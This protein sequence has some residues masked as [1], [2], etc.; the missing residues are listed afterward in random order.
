M[1]N[2]QQPELR[3][4]ERGSTTE[5]GN[6]VQAAGQQQSH[7]GKPHGTDAGSKGGGRGGGTPPEQQSPYP[8]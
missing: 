3:R 6:D 5:D 4:N 1:A 8:S 7:G 2:P